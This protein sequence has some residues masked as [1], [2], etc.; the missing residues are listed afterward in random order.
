MAQVYKTV[1][2]CLY[3]IADIV[4]WM[5]SYDKLRSRAPLELLCP[6]H[7]EKL[8]KKYPLVAEGVMWLVKE[9]GVAYPEVTTFYKLRHISSACLS[10]RHNQNGP[11]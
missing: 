7:D 6:G 3:L 2:N 10:G 1:V 9:T 4:A 5:E 8:F 11:D